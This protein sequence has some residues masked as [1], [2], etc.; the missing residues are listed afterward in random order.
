ME[1]FDVVDKNR[2]PLGYTKPRGDKLEDNE[3][4][5][6]IEVWIFNNKKRFNKSIGVL[7]SIMNRSLFIYCRSAFKYFSI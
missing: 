1:L 7:Y 4:N 3:Y 2:K 5:V 6:G